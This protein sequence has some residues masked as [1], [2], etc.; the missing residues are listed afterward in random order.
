MDFQAI[1]HEQALTSLL[2]LQASTI[3]PRHRRRQ[4][5]QLQTRGRERS[6]ARVKD[7][8]PWSK[9]VRERFEMLKKMDSALYYSSTDHGC[10][11][12]GF[13]KHQRLYD[14]VTKQ[15][16]PHCGYPKL[17]MYDDTMAEVIAV[18]YMLLRIQH[19]WYNNGFINADPWKYRFLVHDRLI[20]SNLQFAQ[21]LGFATSAW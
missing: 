16:V 20:V 4:T 19:E 3:C 18:V 12:Y 17:E 14:A 21:A 13:G 2:E 6:D 7:A 1:R 10:Y 5:L 8:D 9:D 11:T 15:N